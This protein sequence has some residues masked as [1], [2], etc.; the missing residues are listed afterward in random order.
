MMNAFLFNYV[1][2]NALFALPLAILAWCMGRTQ[3]YHSLTHVLW[4]FVLIRLL[5]PPIDHLSSFS[6]TI[7]SRTLHEKIGWLEETLVATL[8]TPARPHP[9]VWWLGTMPQIVLPKEIL[10]GL[11]RG[12]QRLVIAHELAHIQ[13]RDHLVRWLEWA[14]VSWL[15]WNP[16][17]WIARKG[18]RNSEELACDALVLRALNPEPREYGS[19]LLSVAKALSETKNVTPS[20]ACTMTAAQSLEQ[21]IVHIMSSKGKSPPSTLLHCIMI[22]IAGIVVSL[23][24][25]DESDYPQQPDLPKT[26]QSTL[27]RSHESS[28]E[29]MRP[30]EKEKLVSEAYLKRAIIE[31]VVDHVSSIHVATMNSSIHIIRD[32]TADSV[33]IT[34]E[35]EPS[36]DEIPVSL[37]TSDIE[38]VKLVADQDGN[39]KLEVSLDWKD[40]L[41]P[42]RYDRLLAKLT[43]RVPKLKDVTIESINGSLL[44]EGDVGQLQAETVNGEIEIRDTVESAAVE[45]VNGTVTISL[46]KSAC[47]NL[48]MSTINGDISLSLPES[49]Q[50]SLNANASIE[51]IE[52]A[53]LPGTAQ[54]HRSGYRYRKVIGQADNAN[55]ELDTFSGSIHLR[56]R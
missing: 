42:G 8:V 14:A 19:C 7:P 52:L 13:R 49:W 45:S 46:A 17:V 28:T 3:R 22:S 48:E 55:A 23:G 32:E 9:F 21:R 5:L 30:I 51:K 18:L 27:P 24:L 29:T 41:E 25:A 4:A 11:P 10:E 44:V 34:A 12:E 20:I 16:M 2:G 56:R 33:G 47:S 53:N 50:G 39:G 40:Q 37:F 1:I 26:S 38:S 36:S 35:I 54:K 43:L 15:W 31:K 6:M